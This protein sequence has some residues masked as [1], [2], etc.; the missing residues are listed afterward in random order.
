MEIIKTENYNTDEN[1]YILVN[2]KEAVAIDP[3]YDNADGIVK[4]AGDAKIKYILL[5]HCHYDH[6]SAVPEL[7]R[8][9]GAKI[10]ATPE[11]AANTADRR[12]NLTEAG[13]GR[14]I[15]IK[16]A[17]IISD[18]DIELCGMKIKVLKT[19]G[20]TSCGTCFLIENNLFSGDTLF[21]RNIG[22]WDLPT[23]DEETLKKSIKEVLYS[24]DEDI[25]VHPGHGAETTIGYEKKYNFVCRG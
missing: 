13:L 17:Q 15:E 1:C 12:I 7:V 16:D 14:A 22:R 19:P 9:T 5:T 20:H 10:A 4:A 25:R 8:I 23:G 3:G 6:I 24:L 18:E 2:G 11:C 21:L